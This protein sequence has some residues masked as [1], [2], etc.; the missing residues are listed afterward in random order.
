MANAKTEILFYHLTTHSLEKALPKVLEKIYSGGLR[1]FVLT[2]TVEQMHA[3]NASLWTYSSGAFLPHA[4]EGD[5][6]HNP[7]DNPIW[8]STEPTN[9]NNATVL[10]LAGEKIVDDLAGYT[11]C[12]NIFDGN[13]AGAFTFAQQRYELY[14][15]GDYPIVYWKQALDGT[16]EQIHAPF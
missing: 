15:K 3:L 5:K 6:F 2:D 16:W 10:V 12:V 9:K 13:D 14:H 11:R 7:A 1:A 8:I 4:M